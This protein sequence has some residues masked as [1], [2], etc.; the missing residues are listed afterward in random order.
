MWAKGELRRS[1]ET[2]D[3][4]SRRDFVP[5]LKTRRN[6]NSTFVH[7]GCE[8]S[9]V[10]KTVHWS[11]CCFC[12]VRVIAVSNE[13][14]VPADIPTPDD[15][16]LDL[17]RL[18]L[19][20]GVG[21]RMQR[22]LL[23]FFGSAEDIFKADLRLLEQVEGIGP[24]L[25]RLISVAKNSDDA[26]NEWRQCC[27]RNVSLF[28]NGEGSYPRNLS[29]ISDAPMLLYG[30][31][32]I[33]PRDDLAVAIV[34]SRRCTHYGLQQAE[35]IARSLAMA[36]ITVVSGLARG[37][38]AAA[39]RGALAGGG[40]TIAVLAT[41]LLNIYPPE[42]LDLAK[43]VAASGALVCEM[44]LN[45]HPS[46]GLFPQRNRIIS[47]LSLGVI[48]IEAQRKS[49]SL[50]TARHAMEQG[51]EVMAVPGQID[52]LASEGSND[53][54]RD[55]ATLIRNA[56]DVFESLGPLIEP[57]RTSNETEVRSPRE[58]TLNDQE[59]SVLNLVTTQ[60][61]SIDEVLREATIEP[62]RVLATLTILEM[63]RMVKRLPGGMLVRLT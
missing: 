26:V 45:Q 60:A 51:R 49:G 30:R 55:G 6:E 56:D 2:C 20:P 53:L 13:R 34:G 46:P 15:E 61:R 25:A 52:S 22:N 37:I 35:K 28:R 17:L 39:H 50:H 58:L 10:G 31:G 33:E 40:R 27:E 43:D 5:L 19:V 32:T 12:S 14:L 9:V 29:E 47:G 1:D 3:S 38:D 8:R 57:V 18:N 21:P 59:L 54:I 24:K 23:D 11:R 63:K 16:V 36:G 42:H 62:S 7:N 41:G 48:I 44:K 4:K